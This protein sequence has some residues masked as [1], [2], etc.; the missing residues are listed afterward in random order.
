MT[1]PY[2]R[3][4]DPTGFTQGWE[5][6]ACVIG[7]AV[8]GLALAALA[9]LGLAAEI[10]GS[11]WVWPHGVDAIR[12]TLGG[13]ADGHPGHGLPP[14]EAD[15]VA[16]PGP[17][18]LCVVGCETA[19]IACSVAAGLSLAR[20]FRNDGMATRHDAERALGVS[21]LRRAREIIRPD[22]YG[23]RARPDQGNILTRR[24][25]LGGRRVER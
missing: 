19:A 10:F 14:L 22:L 17:T 21:E 18:Y 15:R 6:A 1:T 2:Q 11:G 4:R 16:G 13:L 5:V 25:A 24:S 3:R 8:I 12:H 23:R 20:R 7:L 9:G